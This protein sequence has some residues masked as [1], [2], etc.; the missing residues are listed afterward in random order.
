MFATAGLAV[1]SLTLVQHQGGSEIGPVEPSQ[2]ARGVASSRSGQHIFTAVPASAPRAFF[3]FAD[4][5]PTGER[6]SSTTAT[7]VEI[8]VLEGNKGRVEQKSVSPAEKRKLSSI[9]A[10][11]ADEPA[12]SQSYQWMRP[13]AINALYGQTQA[14]L[15]DL[16][17][18]SLTDSGPIVIVR[19]VSVEE[20]TA[21][22]PPEERAQRAIQSILGG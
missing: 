13:L 20:Q 12:L 18:S 19:E 8:H 3:I 14:R 1:V 17:A 5:T 11:E 4:T 2:G 16:P 15:L 6:K 22:R 10:D 7:R 21:T 9:F